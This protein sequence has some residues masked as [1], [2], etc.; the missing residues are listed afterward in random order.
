MDGRMPLAKGL[1]VFAIARL[2]CYI[3]KVFGKTSL[4]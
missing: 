4:N 1:K 2:R 3:A